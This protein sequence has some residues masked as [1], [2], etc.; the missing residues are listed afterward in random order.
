MRRSRSREPRRHAGSEQHD[1][2]RHTDVD[3]AGDA[4][5]LTRSAAAGS[6]PCRRV[7]DLDEAVRSTDPPG[8]SA[9]DDSVGLR[10]EGGPEQPR[11]AR[12][13]R[14]LAHDRGLWSR[15]VRVK[16]INDLKDANGTT[17]TI[18]CRSTRPCTGPTRLAA[19]RAA[20]CG[21]RSL[22]ARPD[23]VGGRSSRMCTALSACRTTA[24]ATRGLVPASLRATSRR[25]T[26]RRAPGTT[27]SP[28]RPRKLRRHLG[29]R[30]RH[31]RVPEPET[32]PR[33]SGTTT[34][35]SA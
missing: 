3:P 7:R 30:L 5:G 15:P 9:R 8:G 31:L 2:V 35:R 13:Q 18:C 34:T 23:T 6:P 17:C 25:A 20:T 26:P 27:S 4:Q 24:T 1:Q 21:R 19:P 12:S 29:A 10:R 14:A 32:G 22:D 33:R 11:P 28:A 16:W